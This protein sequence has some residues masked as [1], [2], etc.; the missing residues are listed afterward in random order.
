MRYM[1]NAM[2]QPLSICAFHSAASVALSSVTNAPNQAPHWIEHVEM[3]LVGSPGERRDM[4]DQNRGE[5]AAVEARPHPASRQLPLPME[6]VSGIEPHSGD[7][8]QIL[9][10]GQQLFLIGV[11]QCCKIA[12]MIRG[13]AR[14]QDLEIVAIGLDRPVER[15]PA[16]NRGAGGNDDTGVLGSDDSVADVDTFGQRA[17]LR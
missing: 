11:D 3:G 5:I 17:L 14:K 2:P 6:R 12:E 15:K 16:R 13:P 8:K 10:F 7:T 9:L 4:V 1:C